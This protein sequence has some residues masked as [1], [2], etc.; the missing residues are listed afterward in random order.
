[1]DADKTGRRDRVGMMGRQDHFS[2]ETVDAAAVPR[3][4][5]IDI[6]AINNILNGNAQDFDGLPGR[7][8]NAFSHMWIAGL[9]A[10]NLSDHAMNDYKANLCSHRLTTASYGVFRRNFLRRRQSGQG[11]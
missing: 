2:V 11:Q 6:A 8:H 4:T 1:M 10:A 5:I 3:Q 9:S 7:R